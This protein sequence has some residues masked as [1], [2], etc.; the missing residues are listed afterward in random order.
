MAV[1]D[2]EREFDSWQRGLTADEL[3]PEQLAMLRAMV[4]E[5]RADSVERA[6][7]LLDWQGSVIDLTETMHGP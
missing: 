3:T 2:G 6:A 4:D 1:P 5:G 7:Q